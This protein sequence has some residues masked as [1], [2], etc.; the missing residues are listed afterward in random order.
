MD[1]RTSGKTR[2]Y[3]GLYVFPIWRIEA[4][5]IQGIRVPHLRPGE[6][7]LV[8]NA[9]I[10]GFQQT[11]HYCC[12][13]LRNGMYVLSYSKRSSGLSLRSE[14]VITS[15]ARGAPLGETVL[16]AC[17]GTVLGLHCVHLRR[18]SLSHPSLHV[19]RP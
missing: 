6:T 12:N 9:T 19:D 13:G 1:L 16:L 11:H 8:V 18:Y 4:E 7:L 5:D 3:G 17:S 14:Q 2:P 15:E 10:P